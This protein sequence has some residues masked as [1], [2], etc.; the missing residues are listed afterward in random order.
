MID[1]LISSE[2]LKNNLDNP[3]LVILDASQQAKQNGFLN[4]QIKGARFFDIKNDFSDTNSTFPNTFP[5]VIQ[6]ENS[7]RKLGINNTSKIVVYDKMGVFSS[8]RVWWMFK[9]MGHNDIVVLNGGLPDWIHHNF[10]T[11]IPKKRTYNV[12]NFV[13]KFNSDNISCFDFIKHNI[14]SK[15]TLVVDARSADRFNSIVPEPRAELRSGHI[16]NSINLPYSLVLRNGKFKSK[17]ELETIFAVIKTDKPITFSCGSGITACIILLAC[18]SFLNNKK[19][20][21]DGSWTEWAQ[22]SDE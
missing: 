1:S 12:G 20:V 2:W 8:P 18:D 21:Y 19:S 3:N 14:V 16:P 6:F 15:N 7:C 10:E 11:E 13:A 17:Q 5:S 22:L 4:I 9:T